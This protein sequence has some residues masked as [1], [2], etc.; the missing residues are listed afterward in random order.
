MAVRLFC[1]AVERQR[2]NMFAEFIPAAGI[3]QAPEALH[4][5]LGLV[6]LRFGFFR[7]LIECVEDAI[8]RAVKLHRS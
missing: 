3:G 1:R 5:C 4:G 6:L 7:Q 8:R 2:L